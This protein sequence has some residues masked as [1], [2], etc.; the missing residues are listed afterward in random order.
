MSEFRLSYALKP[1][2]IISIYKQPAYRNEHDNP[3]GDLDTPC[4]LT[5]R[6]FIEEFQPYD[7]AAHCHEPGYI[8]VEY[9]AKTDHDP[10]YFIPMDDPRP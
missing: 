9:P 5:G 4:E 8:V 7:R 6:Y 3:D 2:T 10:L 1:G